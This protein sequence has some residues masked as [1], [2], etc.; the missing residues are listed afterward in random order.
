MADIDLMK[1]E[2]PPFAT[3]IDLPPKAKKYFK[4]N[5]KYLL[6]SFHV[7]KIQDKINK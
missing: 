5:S 6:E 2:W 7:G 4:P 1:T 3:L